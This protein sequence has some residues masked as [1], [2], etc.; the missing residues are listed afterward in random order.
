MDLTLQAKRDLLFL[1]IGHFADH[2]LMLIFPTAVLA[3]AANMGA[4]YGDLLALTTGAF[5]AFGIGTVPA[6]WLADRWSKEGMIGVFFV[7]TGA[8]AVLTGL[9]SGYVGLAIALTL[10]GLFAAIY[11]PVGIA[12]LADRAQPTGKV[13][14]ALG[15]NGVW[16]NLGVAAAGLVTAWIAENFGW[17]TAFIA[18]GVVVMGIG[19]LWFARVRKQPIPEKAAK[20]AQAQFAIEKWRLILVLAA[21][22]AI[23]GLVFQVTTVG[24]P[25]LFADRIGGGESA[26]AIDLT[27]IGLLVGAVFS[28]AAVTQI[29]VGRLLDRM[30][31]RPLFVMITLIQVPLL[32]MAATQEGIVLLVSA[33]ALM[34]LVFGEIPLHDALVARYAKPAWRSRVFAVKYF[35]SFGVSSAAVPAIAI[36][37]GAGGMGAGGSG[38]ET[39]GSDGFT[40]LF[41]ALAVSVPLITLAACLLPRRDKAPEAVPAE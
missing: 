23:G 3:M 11:H 28:A 17:R 5:V 40:T 26:L 2:Y 9:V 32:V 39:A 20:T 14:R 12:L 38:S 34:A 13:G 24:L 19:L 22:T 15:V 25:K 29:I 27:D 6:G 8:A 30:A 35:G 1:N 37:H 18:P 36:L 31:I 21:G 7:G 10:V 41:L 16:G 4:N 33:L